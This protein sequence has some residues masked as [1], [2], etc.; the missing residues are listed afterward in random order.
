VE[1]KFQGYRIN[2]VNGRFLV[3]H[4]KREYTQDFGTL[5]AAQRGVSN[6]REKVRRRNNPNKARSKSNEYDQRFRQNNP[7]SVKRS[8]KR[9]REKY[10]ERVLETQRIIQRRHRLTPEGKLNNI[11]S[12]SIR[13]SL[14]QVGSSKQERHWETLVGY[15]GDELKGH[16]E[17]QFVN[18]M[19]WENQ[20]SYWHIDHIRPISSFSFSCA[21]DTGF[22][23]CWTLTNLQPLE[24]ELNMQKGAR[25]DWVRPSQNTERR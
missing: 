14:R 4:P 17:R 11:T 6:E 2:K 3:S 23:E 18:G 1:V 16:L 10:P 20:G 24:K 13:K 5:D 22:K 21:E 12:Q 7:E 8:A 9:F 15:S 19:S 25:L